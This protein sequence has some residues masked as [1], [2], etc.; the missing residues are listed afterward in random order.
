MQ[1]VHN[2]CTENGLKINY[3]K[4]KIMIRNTP[5]KYDHLKIC[6]QNNTHEIE[7]VEDYKYLGMW[8]SKNNKKHLDQLERNGRKSSFITAKLLKE[9][10]QINGIFL[11]DAFEM[12][13][14]SKMK[15]CGEICFNDNLKHL[16]KI[17]YQFY[18]RFCHLY[19]LYYSVTSFLLDR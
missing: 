18:K 17:Q 16:N 15:Y 2:F 13:T 3:D 10:G 7:V 5:T 12:L 8:I 9:F 14:L 4:T 1:L 11:K 6:L 19:S